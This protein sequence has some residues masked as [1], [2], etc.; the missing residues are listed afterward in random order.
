VHALTPLH[1]GAGR[2]VG[3]IDLPIMREKVT[4]W[5][6][7]PGTAVKGVLRDHHKQ[8]STRPEWMDVAFGREGDEHANSGSL[9]F[10]DARIICLPV[11]SLYGTFAWCTSPAVLRRLHRDL[12][13][14]RCADGLTLLPTDAIEP[15]KVHVTEQ[16]TSLLANEGKLFLEDLDFEAEEDP[17]AEVWATR[18]AEYVFRD[19][20]TWQAEFKARFTILPD[21]AFSFLS[22]TATEVNAR[23]RIED[24]K[25]TVASGHLWYEEALPTETILAGLVW[26]DRIFGKSGSDA[27]A[28]LLDLLD[29]FCKES[30]RVQI[31]GNATT[32]KGQARLTFQS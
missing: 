13:A 4:G 25:K 10:T 32:G 19:D 15:T 16:G 28:S 5:P 23:V 26:C 20:N 30:V 6:L 21:D 17:Q 31:G 18:I 1:V 12:D 27:P 22:E 8:A 3:Y 14:A 11:R 7:V 29:E 24:E 9:V 2:G